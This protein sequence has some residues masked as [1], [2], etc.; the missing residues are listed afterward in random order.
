MT[1]DDFTINPD[2]IMAQQRADFLV[3]R[4]GISGALEVAYTQARFYR[5]HI[6]WGPTWRDTLSAVH[7]WADAVE[8]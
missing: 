4:Y 1:T 8:V 6:T 7:A 5:N 2:R 3:Q